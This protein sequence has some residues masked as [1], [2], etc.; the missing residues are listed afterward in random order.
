MNFREVNED[1]ILKRW[2]DCMEEDYLCYMTEEDKKHTPKFDEFSENILKNVPKQSHKY[3]EKQLD[4]IY[5]DFM[6]YFEYVTE[7][8]YRNGFMDGSQLVMGCF[9]E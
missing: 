5:D 2:Y 3:I 1:D 8:Y 4:F 7:K 9:E 6:K